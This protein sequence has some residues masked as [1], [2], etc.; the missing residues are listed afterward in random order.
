MIGNHFPE[1]GYESKL[2]NLKQAMIDL[3]VNYPVVQDNEGINWNAYANHY[4]PTMYLIDKEGHIRYVHIGEGK[5]GETE[6]AINALLHEA[7]P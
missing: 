3:E 6:A 1:F 7:A 4:W 2:D 5:Y